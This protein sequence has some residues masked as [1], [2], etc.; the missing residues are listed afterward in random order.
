MD[1]A[2]SNGEGVSLASRVFEDVRELV[3][4]ASDPHLPLPSP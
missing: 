2:C 4:G 1:G 3:D